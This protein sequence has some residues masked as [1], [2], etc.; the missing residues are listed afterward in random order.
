MTKYFSFT[1]KTAW[2]GFVQSLLDSG[3]QTLGIA[4]SMN[5]NDPDDP[6]FICTLAN[7]KYAELF[8]ASP[9]SFA[10]GTEVSEGWPEP[11][12]A[13]NF[14]AVLTTSA[15]AKLAAASTA[16]SDNGATISAS[17]YALPTLAYGYQDNP[18]ENHTTLMGMW[19]KAIEAMPATKQLSASDITELKS[20]LSESFIDDDGKV[21]PLGAG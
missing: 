21:L 20:V 15:W 10:L 3:F 8:A 11:A 6:S 12:A 19:N 16:N 1:D 14:S 2:D 4:A 18:E 17:M 13:V 7:E 9:G 5:P